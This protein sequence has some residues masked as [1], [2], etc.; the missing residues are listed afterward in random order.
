ME[1]EV[2]FALATNGFVLMWLCVVVA[3]LLPTA[4]RLGAGLLVLGGRV[5]PVVLFLAFSWGV[6]D[7][8]ALQPQGS[9]T[10]FA[11]IVAKFSVPERLLNVWLEILAF[12]LLAAHWMV[13]DARGRGLSRL[14]LLPCLVVTFISAAWGLLLYLLV[15]GV[16]QL[17]RRFSARGVSAHNGD[18]SASS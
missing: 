5:A 7:A 15:L 18:L 9:L 2:R 13:V 4:S 11:G 14:V 17:W 1:N 10:S 6:V 3:G 12:I 8:G 16:W